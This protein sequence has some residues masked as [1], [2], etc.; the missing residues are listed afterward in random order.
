MIARASR[1]PTDDLARRDMPTKGCGAFSCPIPLSFQ[2]QKRGCLIVA[3][4][5]ERQ[6]LVALILEISPLA[7]FG[8]RPILLCNQPIPRIEGSAGRQAGL[9]V[10]S[11]EHC[12][13][14]LMLSQ[15]CWTGTR[16]FARG[17]VIKYRKDPPSIN[18]DRSFLER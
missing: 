3:P 12:G 18:R 15:G 2:W 14:S 4:S 7:E 17:P 9:R 10:G 8:P 1:P 11:R 13:N 5:S 16:R 6:L